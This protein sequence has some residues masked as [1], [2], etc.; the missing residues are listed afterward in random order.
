MSGA[1]GLEVPKLPAIDNADIEAVRSFLPGKLLGRTA[2]LLSLVLLVL[3]WIGGFDAG[4][5]KF[6]GIDLD[7]Q[8]PWLRYG[9]LIVAPMFIVTCQLMI[10]WQAARVRQKTKE[11]AVKIDAV[12]RGYFRIGPYLD[13]PEDR[14]KFDRADQAQEKVLAW[15]LRSSA[16]PLYLTGDSGSGKSSL[17]NAVVLP[18]LREQKWTVVEARAWQDPTTSL[19]EELQKKLSSSRRRSNDDGANELR[20]LIEAV[21]RRSDSGLLMVL[22]Q[23][24]EFVILAKPE[25]RE[26]FSALIASL[27]DNPIKG[28]R[29]LL[30]L[31]R[32]YEDNLGDVGLP[33]LRQYENWYPLGCFSL[34]ASKSF[35]ERSGLGLHPEALEHVLTSAA[36]MD[37][38]PAK[39]RPITLNVVGHVL[40]EG[41]GSAPSLEADR[42]VRDY[43]QQAVEQPGIRDFSRPVLEKL[44]TEQGTKRPRSEEELV[45]QTHLR[46]GEVRAVLNGLG[47]AALA[48][49]LDPAQGVW[50]LSHDF[51]A[52][53]AT[54]YLGRHRR[55]W[56]R[57][58]I[59]YVAP[60]LLVLTL[61]TTIGFVV[62]DQSE[63][64][65][66]REQLQDLGLSSSDKDGWLAVTPN[67]GFTDDTLAKTGPLLEK[68]ASRIYAVGLSGTQVANIE[69]LKDLA[70]LQYLNL[71]RTQVANI[72]PLRGLTKLQNLDLSITHVAN[73]E[74]IKHLAA[75]KILNLQGTGVAN[76]EPLQDLTALQILNLGGTRVANIEPL[77]GLTKL[78]TLNLLA[79]QVAN[80]KPLRGLTKLQKLDL[81]GQPVTN[82]EPL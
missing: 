19:R 35:M 34:A 55:D 59:A 30:V 65:R 66:I 53:A 13:S 80:I 61:A 48:R 79:T 73:I 23:F 7:Q 63:T 51:V 5:K 82:I 70:A 3:A 40:A 60:T 1:H 21:A 22:D 6:L 29:L 25:A 18:R 14:T 58:A 71:T 12:P 47:I 49:P 41:L 42:L 27:R 26:R 38:I 9:L 44:L 36:E 68:L 74:P 43:I 32:D 75:L 17:L 76:I 72:E 54:Y 50:E 16:V 67:A 31:R 33:V 4:L 52:R 8:P 77:Q 10:E 37:G 62:F 39:I 78:Q 45:T 20:T 24:E 64:T 69:P 56:W 57:P 2:A 15:V 11:L 28:L 46:H 81:P